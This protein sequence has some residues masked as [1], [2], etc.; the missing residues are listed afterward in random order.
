MQTLHLP[1]IL[2][3]GSKGEAET[4]DSDSLCTTMVEQQPE[5]SNAQKKW[6]NKFKIPGIL[7]LTDAKHR[8]KGDTPD[9]PDIPVILDFNQ[10][11]AQNH[12]S[13]ASQQLLAKEKHLF[14]PQS[15]DSEVICTENEEDSLQKDYE[16][17][18]LHLRIAVHDSFN[19]ENLE[20]LR[21]AVNVIQQQ[22]EQDRLWEKAAD[23]NCARWRPLK[24]R[25]IHDT[26][27]KE[28]VEMRL[29]Q[30]NE[31]ENGAEKLSTSLKREVCRMGKRIQKDL[32]QVVQ[33][34]QLCYTPDFDICIMYIQLYHQA[35]SRKLTKLAR[36][37]IESQDCI[38]ILQWLHGYYQKNILQLNELKPH[39]NA[40]SLG[41]LLPEEDRRAL[42]EQ[43]V[44]HKEM[45]VRTWLS[46]ALEKEKEF[47]QTSNKPELIDGC[48][49]SHLA[50]DV[51]AI[52]NGAVTETVNILG[53]RDNAQRILLQLDNFLS[54]YKKFIA[55]LI[56]GKEIIVPNTLKASLVSMKQLREYV[57]K[58]EDLSDNM[59]EALLSIVSEMRNSCHC[60][61]LSPIH[62]ELKEQYCK[63]WTPVWFSKS[64]ALI[65]DLLMVL[66]DKIHRLSDIQT[67]CR[68]GSNE[69]WLSNIL[70]RL[71]EVLQLQ[72]PGALQ[73]EI[74]TLVRTYPDISNFSCTVMNEQTTDAAYAETKENDGVV[75]EPSPVAN[76]TQT[77]TESMDTIENAPND[78]TNNASM[79]TCSKNNDETGS[80]PTAIAMI[81][82]TKKSPRRSAKYFISHML[83]TKKAGK[84]HSSKFTPDLLVFSKNLEMGY[85]AE[86]SQQLLDREMCL[87]ISQPSSE[88]VLCTDD[89]KNS[90]KKDYETLM[91]HLKMAVHNSFNI[92]NQEMLRNAITAIVQQ[93]E[94][95]RLWEEASEE[96]PLWRPMRCLLIHDTLV[97]EV[98][99]EQL[100]QVN[101]ADSDADT[102]KME[103]VRLGSVIQNDLLQVVRHVQTCYPPDRDVCNM[104]A[105]LYHQAFSATLRKLLQWSRNL[106]DNKFILQQ[107]NSY[108]KN[109]LQL[110]KLKPHINAESLGSLLP[111]EDHKSL[112][113]QYLSHKE[114]EVKTWL[115]N[116][117]KLKEADWQANKKP[118]LTDGYYFCD[119]AVDVIWVVDGAIKEIEVVLGNNN[120][121]RILLQMD[122][123]LMSYKNSMEKFL[124][125]QPTNINEIVKSQLFNI[126][127]IREYIKH[128]G[129]LPDEEKVAWLSMVSELRNS[130]HTY[131]LNPIHK[132]LMVFS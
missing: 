126:E 58:Q 35:F 85:L 11:L 100:Q 39:I 116:A 78:N 7:K 118:E 124:K 69:K 21:S 53:N 12:L 86:A 18:L 6:K 94:Q 4:H 22:E 112:K 80:D 125:N 105:Q 17:L 8:K 72:D 20:K 131:L 16:T 111:E 84:K 25:E 107:M 54:S 115:S 110:D 128:Q 88:E 77:S 36:T 74:V 101:G 117:L 43:Y 127:K 129:D 104:Y 120:A 66:E 3:R 114:S 103:V 14:S 60:Y 81:E 61:F 45:E 87:F 52:I 130:C 1:A 92:E 113:E 29:Q 67:A 63:L 32:L 46:N 44:S 56:K 2:R 83:K 15:P 97:K 82:E 73:L 108:S 106:E 23:G 34:I 51:I 90:L 31:E 13:E 37:N 47:W 122:S 71:S 50:V 38:Y 96:A 42:E 40:E 79:A 109:I 89:A 70:P 98:V 33:H 59:K 5:E 102:L 95:D 19:E 10:N 27:L 24:C 132:E 75:E 64:H 121:Q 93:E 57:E 91:D 123:F 28:V 41:A 76:I 119:F 99:E 30:T 65:G 49:F 26:L 9:T 55:D 62:K 68:K 48:H